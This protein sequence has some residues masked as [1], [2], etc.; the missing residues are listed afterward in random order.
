MLRDEQIYLAHKAANPTK[1]GPP[2]AYLQE[3]PEAKEILDK[4]KPTDVQLQVWDDLCHVAPTLSFTRP[5][6]FMYRSIA[7]FGAWALA[8][9]QKTEIDIMDDD[10][11]SVISSASSTESLQKANGKA[12]THTK[13]TPH[14]PSRSNTKDQSLFSGQIGKAGDPLPRFRNH[15]IRQKVDRHGNIFPLE[16]A[17]SLDALKLAP[18]EI[19][20]IKPGPV[21]KWLAAKNEW[22]TKFSKER[23]RVK[24]QRAR[25]IAMGYQ[26]FGDG[27]V[28]PPSALAGR[29]GMPM[30]EEKKKR[31]LGLSLWSLWGSSH[32]EKTVSI[33][34]YMGK[35]LTHYLV[36]KRRKGRQGTRNNCR[37]P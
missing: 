1:Y 13:D 10:E 12:N 6:K 37:Y 4:Y 26:T 24:K 35:F 36:G 9:A 27:E 15:M 23:K 3:H 22:D 19:G 16:S 29:R 18:E 30:P 20:V 31:S 11:V 33:I 7:Q 32:D 2:E 17:E 14:H 5:A 28:P 34:Y 21:R 25:E 8:K